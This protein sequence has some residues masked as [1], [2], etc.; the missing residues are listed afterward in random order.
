ML[1]YN[2]YEREMGFNELK[3][4][5]SDL[6][7]SKTNLEGEITY[8][9]PSFTKI[10]GYRSRELMDQN[11]N[12]IR[13]PDMPKALFA[14]I[15]KELKSGKE[16]YAFVKNL[17]KD[18]SFY[19]VFAYMVPDYNDKGKIIGYHS[20]RRAPNPKAIAEISILYEQIKQIEIREDL[21]AGLAHLKNVASQRA[22]NYDNYIYKLQNQQ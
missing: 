8:A 2:K 9:N 20:E 14:Y 13:H 4:N 6:I 19:W 7:V 22:K 3:L 21:E 1:N 12:I 16:L 15:W 5:Q 10:S 11:H 18:G 17:T